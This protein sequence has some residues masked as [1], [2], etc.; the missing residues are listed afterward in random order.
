MPCKKLLC[1][2]IA[3]NIKYLCELML[4]AINVPK[5]KTRQ[6]TIK[7]ESTEKKAAYRHY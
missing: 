7:A 4:D 1:S 3:F 2:P 6:C 5:D